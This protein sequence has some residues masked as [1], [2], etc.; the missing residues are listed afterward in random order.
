MLAD[1]TNWCF[2]PQATTEAL[3]SF[4]ALQGTPSISTE[5]C[6]TASMARDIDSAP[7]NPKPAWLHTKQSKPGVGGAAYNTMTELLLLLW[8]CVSRV[9]HC[10]RQQ[11]PCRPSYNMPGISAYICMAAL[12]CPEPGWQK[13]CQS[14]T[15]CCRLS[16]L[17]VLQEHDSR[18]WNPAGRQGNPGGAC[19]F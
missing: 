12:L 15:W 17:G 19:V 13:K 2:P 16:T 7:C 9:P 4:R 8:P 11:C 14:L 1:P 5:P 18:E 6:S 3:L 10:T